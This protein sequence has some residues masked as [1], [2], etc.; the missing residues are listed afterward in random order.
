MAKTLVIV[1]SPTKART[2]ERFLGDRYSVKSSF[3]HVRDLPESASQ[4]P[5][6]I[7]KEKWGR[8]G[9]DV[10]GDFKPYYVVPD[11]KRK[12]VQDLKTALKGASE[13]MLATDPDREGESI[14]WHLL[15]VLKPK[16]PV[17]RIVFHEITKKAVEQAILD[18]HDVDDN[19]VRAQ[20]SRRILDRL[21]GYTVSPVLWKKVQT[22]LSA[23]RV[24]S[25]AVRL[26]VDREE[27]RL[28][29]HTARYSDLAAQFTADGRTFGGTL[30]R[31]GDVRIASGKD[32]DADGVLVGKNVRL[33]SDADAVA[34]VG[35]LN[36]NLPWSVTSVEAKPGVERP[37]APFTTS[38]LTQEASRKLGFS[39]QRTMQ[40]AQRLFQDGHI[41][42]HRTDSTTLSDEALAES[43]RAIREL[44]GDEYYAAPRRYATK[45]KNAQEA[46]EAIRPTNFGAAP[47]SLADVSG[48]DLRVYELIWKRTMA[49]QM[50]DA[51]VL[52]TTIEISARADGGQQAVFSASGKA[53]EF[54]GFRRA[55]VEGSDDPAAE[56]EEQET[57]LPTLTVGEPV[58]REKTRVRLAGL[59]PVGHE[60]NP[61]ARYTEASLIK[62]LERIGV[63]RPSTF[64]AT[65]GTIERRG[66]VFRQG[67]ALVP[68]FTAFAVTRL[69]REHFGD[70]IDVEFT[71]EMEE[72]LDQISR[73]ERE[74]LDFIKQF[75]RGDK[76]HRGLEDAVK[77]A[78][79]RAEYPLIDVGPDPD[80][81]DMIRVRIGRYGPFLQQGEGGPGRTAGIPPTLAPADLTVEKSIALIRAKAEGP[82]LLG[83]DPKTGMNVYAINGRFGAYVQLGETPEKGVKEKPKRS[84]LTGSLTESTVTLEDALRLLELPRELGLH[85]E[86]Q[87][88]IVA[89]L[90]RF[91]P[92]IKHGDDYR[93]LEATDDLFTVDLERALALLAAPKRS[94]RQAAKRVIRKIDVP[95]GGTALQVLE[96]RYGPYVTD[97]ELNA[98]IPKGTD[99][100]TISLEDARALLDARRGAPPREPRRGRRVAA[101]GVAA[102]GAAA[103]GRGRA[104]RPAEDAVAPP[105]P[106]VKSKAKS[107]PFAKKSAGRKRAV[108]KRAS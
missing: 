100:A 98:S 56:L 23:G 85:P 80:S 38:T 96:G 79:E 58:D 13:V 55:Y 46:H 71:A 68:S 34:L 78:E 57:V 32:F 49:S 101:K 64:A 65:I 94:A 72:D 102:K 18:A 48:D 3:G 97:G 14:S 36:A 104:A 42:Y 1:E 76:H 12:N 21:Y 62:E 37:A 47:A 103:R 6:E 87:Q 92:Y 60:T 40:A 30:T 99:P 50:V 16:V 67:K 39:T 70:L 88:P 61:P 15:Q 69:L 35:T 19:L 95:D 51:R 90:G 10:D 63:G 29:F 27:E 74:W 9:V 33:L 5:L 81:G 26:I 45:V 106:P 75:Y 93:S 11:D 73:G 86:S 25:V 44:F 43:A 83:V 108:R 41:S 17:K 28:A 82:R 24:Q 2:L 4:V 20:E 105:A 59:E 77:Q 91:G 7:K 31:V 8:L 22:G 107:K 52:R 66:Y 89:G 54:A 84:S 53:I